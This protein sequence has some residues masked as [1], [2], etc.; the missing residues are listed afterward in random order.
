[1]TQGDESASRLDNAAAWLNE[2]ARSELGPPEQMLR[3][4]GANVDVLEFSKYA[5]SVVEQAR[6]GRPADRQMLVPLDAFLMGF[7]LGVVFERTPHGS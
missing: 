5:S 3:S 7:A 1:M 4:I 2:H 6:R